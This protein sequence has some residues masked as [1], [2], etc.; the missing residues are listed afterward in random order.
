MEKSTQPTSIFRQIIQD[1]KNSKAKGIYSVCSAHPL[2]L[3]AAMK[4]ARQDKSILLIEST[5]NQVNQ[6]GGYMSMRPADF[7]EFVNRI[8]RDMNF[9][10]ENL[11]LGGDHLG[12]SVWQAE[13]ARQAMSKAKDLVMEYV[14]AGYS[15]IHLDASMLLGGDAAGK[16]MDKELIAQR[17]AELC[18]AAEEAF[19]SRGEP[20]NPPYYVIG[21]EVPIPGGEVTAAN[22]LQVSGVEETRETWEMTKAAFKAAG[23]ENAWER[24]VALVVQPGV[25]FGDEVVFNYSRR[26]AAG[27]S[28]LCEQYGSFVFEA[29]STDYQPDWALRQLVEDHFAIL[30]V[31]PALTF[32]MREALFALAMIENEWLIGKP[33]VRPSNLV[34]ELDKAMQ[35]DPVH[36]VKYY[37]GDGFSQLLARKYS[38]SDRSRYY[39]N[40]PEVRS[41]LDQLFRNLDQHPVPLTLLSQFLPCQF[42]HVNEDLIAN[43]PVELVQDKVME[44][45][46]EYSAACGWE[47]AAHE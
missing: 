45:L 6:Y 25:E 2:V 24:V 13:P 17:E 5:C 11:V 4:Q 22:T 7:H 19:Q 3:Q 47:E 34:V 18:L 32:A 8:A 44:I 30:K 23:L 38:Y 28:K 14:Q 26:S 36:W 1:Q 15:K 21:S 43:E 39:W 31:G 20:E 40:K 41:A 9:P 42:H 35:L 33:G 12:P 29:H 37:K 46:Q 16:K 27:L 10:L